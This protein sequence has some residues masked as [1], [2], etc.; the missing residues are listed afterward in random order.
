MVIALDPLKTPMEQAEGLFKR[1]RKLR[2][3]VDA[4]APLLQAAQQEAEYLETVRLQDDVCWGHI[5]YCAVSRLTVVCGVA[6]GDGCCVLLR[7][8]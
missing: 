1:A 2:R 5:G 3:A 4:V 8:C 7:Q 6:A